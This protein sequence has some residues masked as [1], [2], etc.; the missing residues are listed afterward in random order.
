MAR[1]RRVKTHDIVMTFAVRL[2][3]ERR[4]RGMSQQTLAIKAGVTISYIGKIERAESAV[5][6]DMVGRLCDALGLD[7]AELISMKAASKASLGVAREQ[8]LDHAKKLVRHDDAIALEAF[9]VVMGL[10]ENALARQNR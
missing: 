10:A 6:L 3:E 4:K 5:G 2:R 8:V 9:S 1:K 7:P